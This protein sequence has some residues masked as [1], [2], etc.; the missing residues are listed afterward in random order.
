MDGAELPTEDG[1]SFARMSQRGRVAVQTDNA[2]PRREQSRTVAAASQR[3]VEK[4]FP[5]AR[6]EHAQALLR[7]DG[8]VPEVFRTCGVVRVCGDRTAHKRCEH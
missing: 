6:L 7:H 5:L 1:E 4:K 3:A 2:R 8:L